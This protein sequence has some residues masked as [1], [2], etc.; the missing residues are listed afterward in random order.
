MHGISN[1]ETS[2]TFLIHPR[3]KLSKFIP[4]EQFQFVRTL[5]VIFATLVMRDL[6]NINWRFQWG[7]GAERG[8]SSQSWA[9]LR[10]FRSPFSFY[11]WSAGWSKWSVPQCHGRAG[12]HARQQ[13][14][15]SD[16]EILNLLPRYLH[17]QCFSFWPYP[18]LMNLQ[19]ILRRDWR[20][21]CGQDKRGGKVNETQ[22]TMCQEIWEFLRGMLSHH[23]FF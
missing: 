17:I 18:Y 8:R 1:Q 4:E 20:H 2:G 12:D 21:G 5:L 22:E 14:N 16:D 3:D 15:G 23:F 6:I 19:Q 10:W 13:R 7:R 9:L 11:G